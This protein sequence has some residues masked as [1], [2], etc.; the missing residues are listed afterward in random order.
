M[1]RFYT[2]SGFI[3]LYHVIQNCMLCVISL[4]RLYSGFSEHSLVGNAIRSS[5]NN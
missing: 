3:G 1:V 5:L 4:V 2:Q